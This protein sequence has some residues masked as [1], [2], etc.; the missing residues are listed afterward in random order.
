MLKPPHYILAMPKNN[1]VPEIV[2]SCE[3]EDVEE[4]K[5]LRLSGQYIYKLLG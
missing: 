3:K 4:L 5:E 1:E 2:A